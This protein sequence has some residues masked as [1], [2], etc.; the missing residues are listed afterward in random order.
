MP[1]QN[2]YQTLKAEVARIDEAQVAKRQENV[3]EGFTNDPSPKA[4]IAGKEYQIF[5]SNDYLG[6]RHH[7]TLKKAEHEGSEQYGAGPGA[8]RFISGSLKVHRDLEKALAKFHGREDA[9]VFSSAF[10]ANLAVLFSLIKGQSKDSLLNNNTLVLSDELNHRSI[11]DGI[12][13]A[14]LESEQKQIFPHLKPSEAAQVLESNKDKFDRVVIVTD[15]VFSMLGEFQDLKEL[16]RVVDQYDSVYKEGV[17]LVVDD[18]HGVAGSGATGRGTEEVSGGKADVLIGTLGKGFG[19]DGGYVVADQV[20]IDYLRES[21]ATYIYSNSISGATAAAALASVNLVDSAEGQALLASAKEN[22][23]YFK[24]EMTKAGFAFAADSNHAIQPLLIGDATKTKALTKGLFDEGVLVTNINYPV[25]PKGRDEI[26][27]QISATHTREDLVE[28][29]GK[30][31]E[32]AKKVGV[33][34]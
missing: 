13:L 23:A 1:K 2:F 24:E 16:R 26:R 7:V 30:I 12:R 14:G 20:V 4:I 34:A 18:A 19:A 21:A 32:V 29:I 8:V 25:V 33:L 11:I 27:V 22:I 17:L 9:M 28:F 3:I 15:G 5:N 10:A 6:L 31:T